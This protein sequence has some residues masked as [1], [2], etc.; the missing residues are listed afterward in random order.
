MVDI[1]QAKHEKQ[2]VGKEPENIVAVEEADTV[3]EQYE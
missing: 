1:D 3:P 2:D